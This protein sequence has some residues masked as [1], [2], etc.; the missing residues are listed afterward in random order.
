MEYI[1]RMTEAIKKLADILGTLNYEFGLTMDIQVQLGYHE[2]S[3]V[4]F[5]SFPP[6][7]SVEGRILDQITKAFVDL[8]WRLEGDKI[9]V[10]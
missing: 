4:M 1:E 6:H 3:A 8:T 2:D 9:R 5:I 7:N 10:W